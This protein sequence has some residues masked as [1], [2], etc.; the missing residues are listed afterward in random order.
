MRAELAVAV[1]GFAALTA[2]PA[3][4]QDPGR[5]ERAFQRCYACHSVDPAEQGLTGPNLH[6]IV[7]RPAAADPDFRYSEAFRAVA[8]EG[9]VWTEEALDAFLADPQAAVPDNDMEF[10]GLRDAG[11]RRD[12]IAYLI[13]A[14]E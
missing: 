4:A 7:G 2:G 3:F 5:G 1:A 12:L 6:G 14:A 10:F 8:Q 11:D 9:L 13:G